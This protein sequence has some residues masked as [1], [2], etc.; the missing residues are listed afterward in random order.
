MG[1]EQNQQS[2]LGCQINPGSIPK[3]LRTSQGA[4]MAYGQTRHQFVHLAV[5]VK[6]Q[7]ALAATAIAIE[8]IDRTQMGIGVMVPAH[9]LIK[10]AHHRPT[11]L[12]MQADLAQ[13]K[14]QALQVAAG[15]LQQ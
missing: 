5:G 12:Q 6:A 14:A 15:M 10:F 1:G 4:P 11:A 3:F 9:H 7:T 2:G 13:I 8:V